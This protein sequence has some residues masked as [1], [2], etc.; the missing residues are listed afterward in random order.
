MSKLLLKYNFYRFFAFAMSMKT[1]FIIIFLLIGTSLFSQIGGQTSFALLGLDFNAR[2]SGLAGDFI[3]AKDQDINMGVSNP[4]LLNN[5]M[6]QSI[7]V[8]Q[9]LHAGRINYGMLSYGHAFNEKQVLSTHIRYVAYGK[10]M[11]TEKNGVEMGNFSPFEYI[12]GVG[13]GHQLN[14]RISVGANLNIIGSH[15]E[16]YNSYGVSVDLAGTFTNA[17][18]TFLLTAMF[19][20]AGFQFNAYNDKR[21]P[22]PANFQLGASYR[23]KHAPFRFSILAHHLNKW[24]LSYTDPTAKP[25]V[26]MLTG[27]TIPVKRAGFFEKLGQHFTYQ[28]EILATKNIHL[29]T[30]FDYYTR[31]S[32]KLESKPGIAGF[33]FGLG[34]YFKRFS[35]DYGFSLFSKAGFNNMLTIS[36]NL[37][38]IKI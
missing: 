30:G 28:L 24:D 27:E 33:S 7:S 34:L 6:H 10:M 35:L 37:S 32:M 17:S 14:P 23:L 18:E 13:Y 25:T 1:S 38:K 31:Q 22:L 5:K 36:A 15:L 16:V 4:S 8:S 12:V 19:K 29:R 3:T 2:S 21:A 11:R 20:N 26:D 9:A